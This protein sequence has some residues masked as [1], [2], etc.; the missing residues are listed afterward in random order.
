MATILPE[1]QSETQPGAAFHEQETEVIMLEDRLPEWFRS[2]PSVLGLTLVLGILFVVLSSTPLYHTDLWGHLNYGRE[3]WSSGSLPATEP[4]LPL[5]RGVQMVDSAWLTQLIGFGTYQWLG[6]AGLKFLFAGSVTLTAA[7][8]LRFVYM[9]TGGVFW[10][11]VALLSFVA[12]GWMQLTIIRPQMAAL[13]CFAVLLDWCWSGRRHKSDWFLIPLVLAA[14]ANLHGSFIVGLLVLAARSGGDLI[15]YWRTSGRLSLAIRNPRFVRN[16]LLLQLAAVATL[17]NPYGLQLHATVLQ[18]SQNPNLINLVD[19]DPLTMRMVQ[20]RWAAALAVACV[21]AAR[22]T[23]RRIRAHEI[24]LLLG[25]GGMALWTS[26]MLIWWAPVAAC[27]IA[28][29]GH[30][31]WKRSAL[32][33][34][35]T[36]KTRDQIRAARWAE[37][38]NPPRSLWSVAA[39]GLA[40]IA[41]SLT[42]LSV[43]LRTGTR[44]E[45]STA[46]TPQTPIAVAEFVDQMPDRPEGVVFNT[47]EWGDYLQWRC[48]DLPIFANSHVHLLPNEVW[49]HFIEISDGAGSAQPLLDRYGVNMLVLNLNHHPRLLSSL[50]EN[51]ED[52]NEVYTDDM[53]A[54][55]LRR[56]PI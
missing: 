25:L 20:G 21:L 5:A 49:K 13:V 32:Y 27:F 41:F 35:M 23:P 26:R 38:T 53:A 2:H 7:L 42:P 12:V 52:W 33:R 47:Y 54:V 50:R 34:R 28:I 22:A 44:Q 37:E 4:T 39:L 40:F 46:V 30:A 14:W 11:T 15:D 1:Q 43:Q 19:W 18:F 45:F 6:T 9:K 3:I 24:L 48:K 36:R 17:C 31:A 10:P 29:H 8:L 51:R 56:D 16:L 55:F